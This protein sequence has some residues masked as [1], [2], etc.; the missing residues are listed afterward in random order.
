MGRRADGAR[1]ELK[2]AADGTV[3][4]LRGGQAP[5][6]QGAAVEPKWGGQETLYVERFQAGQWQTVQTC[7]GNTY[8]S[9]DNYYSYNYSYSLLEGDMALDAAGHAYLA[10][11]DNGEAWEDVDDHRL[12]TTQ[13]LSTTAPQVTRHYYAGNQ[14][15]ASRVD[16]TL[17]YVL[18]EPSG[19][20]TVF[21]DDTG[22]EAGHIIYDA[23][24]SVVEMTPDLPA[25][26][27]SHLDASGLQW[28]GNRYY[29]PWAGLYTQPNPF[30]GLPDA[31]QSLNPFAAVSGAI[32]S[33]GTAQSGD[34]N[35]PPLV[36]DVGK[37]TV[38]SLASA[39]LANQWL[40]PIPGRL[41]SQAAS[42]HWL[43][44]TAASY[45]RNSEQVPYFVG[46]FAGKQVS[47]G[48]WPIQWS[49]T[50]S[51]GTSYNVLVRSLP[52]D[53]EASLKSLSRRGVWVGERPFTLVPGRVWNYSFGLNKVSSRLAS[54]F[55]VGSFVSGG[56]ADAIVGGL[57]QGLEDQ[58]KYN[59]WTTDPG[60]AWRRVE[61]NAGA[62]ATVDMIGTGLTAGGFAFYVGVL[63]FSTPPGWVIVGTTVVVTVGIG[64]LTPY[65]EQIRDWWFEKLDA[66]LEE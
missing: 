44:I 59:L 2:V 62:N 29:D 40:Q 27:A 16:D 1:F 13:I 25:S 11:I 34:G 18:N 17:Y 15:I 31:P 50:G 28:D 32:A 12:R 52:D 54:H 57:W 39:W 26:L 51:W 61:A 63:G 42:W 35:L 22:A 30:G 7:L 4:L 46:L 38:S 41:A 48:A 24:G 10:W 60:L 36:V 37:S 8:P 45:I 49:K 56:V 23:L 47:V 20:G 9:Q 53:F 14:R 33:Y 6:E 65:G 43:K 55:T 66:K 19:L 21:V 5:H 58:Y 3:S 64:T